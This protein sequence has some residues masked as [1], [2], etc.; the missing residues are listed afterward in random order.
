MAR[1]DGGEGKVVRCETRGIYNRGEQKK[2]FLRKEGTKRLKT[3][4]GRT[5][6]L[7]G[8]AKSGKLLAV[9]V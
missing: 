6:M 5:D 2:T 3:M 7:Q 1:G 9:N 4:S 8:K